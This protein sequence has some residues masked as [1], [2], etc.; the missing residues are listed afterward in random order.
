MAELLKVCDAAGVTRIASAGGEL[1]LADHDQRTM[2]YIKAAMT[3]AEIEKLS[4]R[5]WR[6]SREN[7]ERGKRHQG[8][9]RPF[10]QAWHGSQ[11]AGEEQAAEGGS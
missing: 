5:L 11:A 6:K 3:E 9:R 7:A 4:A 2:L 8:G 10:G 1:N